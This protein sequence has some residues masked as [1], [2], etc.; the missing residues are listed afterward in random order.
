M[1]EKNQ[2]HKAQIKPTEMLKIKNVAHG[3]DSAVGK[4]VDREHKGLRFE[5]RWQND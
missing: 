5:S 4:V 2:M 3:S 1:L